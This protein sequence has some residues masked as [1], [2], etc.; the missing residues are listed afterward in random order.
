MV[1]PE[2]QTVRPEAQTADPGSGPVSMEPIEGNRALWDE[3]VAI[4]MESDFYDVEG[5]KQGHQSL[6]RIELLEMGS[7][8]GRSLLH[9]QC[10]FG[11]DTLSLARLG[12]VV[13]GADFSAEAVGAARRLADELGI[14][15]IFVCAGLYELPEVIHSEFDF[16]FTSYGALAWLPDIRRWARVVAHFLRPGGTFYM[17]EF[18]PI[19]DAF[20]GTEAPEPEGP[21][22]YDDA[23]VEWKCDGTYAEPGAT[24]SSRSNQWHHPVGDVISALVEAGL[25]IQ[26]LHEHPDVHEQM[27]PW[28]VQDD[29]GRF[30][31]PRDSLPVLYSVRATRND[32]AT[33]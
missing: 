29:S 20:G 28:M 13:T 26:F 23:P 21:Y 27:R 7:V 30:R 17:V 24:V 32:S 9:L 33:D 8:A 22:F 10:H 31:A 14:D 4:H 5:F 6:R 19:V 2:A 12:A 3:L 16:V 25:T 1:R 15:A 18:H 11:L